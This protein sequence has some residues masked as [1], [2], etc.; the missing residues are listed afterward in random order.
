MGNA[1]FIDW[2]K[3]KKSDSF[4]FDTNIWMYFYC[5]IGSYNQFIVSKYDKFFKKTLAV[6]SSIFVSSLIL[7]EF[8]NAYCRLE[9]NILR[10]ND[11]SRYNDYK[12]NFKKTK[13]YE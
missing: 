6:G 9:F 10:V 2:C 13:A 3:P 4:F 8:F 1:Y 5:P 11:P 7:S 12:K